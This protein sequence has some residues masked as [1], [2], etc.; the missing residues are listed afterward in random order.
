MRHAVVLVFAAIT[1]LTACGPKVTNERSVADITKH[2]PATLEAARPR[3]GEPRTVKVRVWADAGVRALPKWKEEIGDQ[4]D[5]ASQL[6]TPMLGVRLAIDKIGDWNRAGDPAGALQ[7]LAEADKGDQVTWVIGYVTPADTASKAMSELGNAEPLGKYVVVRAWAEKPESEAL[8]GS[9]PDLKEAERTE[10]LAA[11]RRHKQ[12]V[13]LL[14]ML[15]R[16]LGAIHESDPA[17]IEHPLYSPKQNTFADRTRELLQ[18]AVDERIAGGDDKAVAAKLLESI[19]KNAWGG[20]IAANQEEVT[21]RLRMIV[22]T[23]KAGKTAAAVPAAAYDQYARIK[24]LAKQGKTSDALAELDN[25]LVAYPGNAAMH[26]LKCEILLAA[27]TRPKPAPAPPGK[28][29]KAKPAPPAKPNPPDDAS[30]AACKKA[31]DLA[32]GD[33]S[34]HIA[35]AQAL[36]RVD[37]LKGARA[38]LAS[39]E[40]K[41]ANLS[42][43][44]AEEAWRKLIEMYQGMGALTWTEAAIGKAKLDKDPVAAQVAQTRA[45]YG[46]PK[47]AKFVAPDQE[48]AL[49]AAIRAALDLVYASK[50]PE[51]ERALATADKKWPGAPGLAAARCDLDLRMGRVDP[52]RAACERALAADPNDSWALYLSGVIGLKTAAGT[53]RGIEQ[54]KKAISVDPDLGQAWRTLGKAYVR[55]KDRGA[56]EKLSADYQA[57]FGTPLPP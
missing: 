43:P 19:E 9:L 22:D 41:V 13:I 5:Y 30:R 36:A 50:Y 57:K 37:D 31:S 16:T 7:A 47:G 2:L 11:H 27:S 49:V 45:R 12:T 55:A 6:L 23:G 39:A 14:H 52:A 3:D 26:Q 15:A 20:W 8:A 51:A 17:W 10:V 4:I 34:P 32:P 46:I 38:E 18:L 56:W 33:P 29:P 25:L 42:G 28:D 1:A 48:A 24:E 35:V 40:A 21:K 54:L 44:Q 53:P